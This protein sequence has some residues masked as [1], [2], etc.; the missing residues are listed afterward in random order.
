[1][2]FLKTLLTKRPTRPNRSI[3][4]IIILLL[5]FNTK[6]NMGVAPEK[7]GKNYMRGTER[8]R[9]PSNAKDLL[10]RPALCYWGDSVGELSQNYG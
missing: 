4:T 3:S 5:P 9:T 8:L 7:S 1:M 6:S 10:P 2:A